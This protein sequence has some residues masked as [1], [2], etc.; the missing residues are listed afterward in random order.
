MSLVRETVKVSVREM[1]H[2]RAI[3]WD[4]CLLCVDTVRCGVAWRDG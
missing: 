2:M 1:R 3:V 4:C